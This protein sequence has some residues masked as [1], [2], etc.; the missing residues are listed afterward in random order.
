MFK[1][2]SNL[3]IFILTNWYRAQIQGEILFLDFDYFV[4]KY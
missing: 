1:E 3:L 4:V 2:F